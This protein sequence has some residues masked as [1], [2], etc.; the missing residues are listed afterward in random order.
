M[1]LHLILM[2]IALVGGGAIASEGVE[3]TKLPPPREG[4]WRSAFVEQSQSF[5]Q[6]TQTTKKAQSFE[7]RVV[8]ILPLEFDYPVDATLLKELSEFLSLFFMTEV[9]LLKPS[10]I[11]SMVKRRPSHGFGAQM[12]AEDM[13]LSSA[14]G[15]HEKLLAR[16]VLTSKDL[17]ARY[18][19]EY[20]NFLF[21][22]GSYSYR[23][24]VVSEARLSLQYGLQLEVRTLRRRLFKIAA[25]ELA[26][27]LNLAHCQKYK[28]L[29]NGVNSISELDTSPMHLCPE[30]SH[31]LMHQLG[32]NPAL[33][34]AELSKFYKKIKWEKC[35]KFTQLRAEYQQELLLRSKQAK[36]QKP[37]PALTAN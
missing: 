3:F 13:I 30:C 14:K 29:M 33:R 20:L 27:V 8:E 17:F 12:L 11:S 9:V 10:S 4:D 35:S 31:K 6:F 22:L 37:S 28:C 34:F 26:H 24:A 32:Y 36:T 18:N 23:T 15:R 19:R 2:L 1:R 16:L 21:G 5:E 7:M 25:H